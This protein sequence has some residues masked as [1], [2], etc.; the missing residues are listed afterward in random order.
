M[1]Q[2]NEPRIIVDDDWK[3]EA[4]REKERLEQEAKQAEPRG[5][6]QAPSILELVQMIAMQASIGLG[7]YQDPASGH[8][9]P[10][11]MNVARH[12]IDLLAVLIDKTRGNLDDQEKQVME[13]LLGELRMAFVQVAGVGAGGAGQ[14]PVGPA[15]QQ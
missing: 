14:S 4:Q 7:G 5:E 8:N 11:N 10:P 6:M 2:D 3:L 1:A 12:F 13:G 9:I 15:A